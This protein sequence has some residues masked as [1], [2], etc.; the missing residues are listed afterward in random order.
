MFSLV[1]PTSGNAQRSILYLKRFFTPLFLGL[2]AVRLYS[3]LFIVNK[4]TRNFFQDDKD[5]VSVNNAVNFTLTSTRISWYFCC[6][7]PL[8]DSQP[9]FYSLSSYFQTNKLIFACVDENVG[10]PVTSTYQKST[11]VALGY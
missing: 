8:P 6:I 7:D 5:N 4:V 1:S 3:I 11:V 2:L 9:F 10:S